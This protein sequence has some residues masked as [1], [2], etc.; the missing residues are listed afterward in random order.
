MHRSDPVLRLVSLVI[1][2]V[3]TIAAYLVAVT[4]PDLSPILRPVSAVVALLL[5]AQSLLFALVAYDRRGRR[6]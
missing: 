5:L 2:G 3:S 6:G 4:G 1:S